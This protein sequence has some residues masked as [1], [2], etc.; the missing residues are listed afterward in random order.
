MQIFKKAKS[1]AKPPLYWI[2]CMLISAIEAHLVTWPV[3]PYGAPEAPERKGI[4]Y[5]QQIISGAIYIL[6]IEMKKVKAGGL[7]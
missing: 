7:I 4:T 6:F 3:Q 5:F 2:Y 1:K